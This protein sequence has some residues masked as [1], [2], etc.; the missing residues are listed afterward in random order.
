M[1]QIR[2]GAGVRCNSCGGMTVEWEMYGATFLSWLCTCCRARGGMGGGSA[3]ID[4]PAALV[5]RSAG[6]LKTEKLPGGMF[7]VGGFAAV[8]CDACTDAS[9]YKNINQCLRYKC[10]FGKVDKP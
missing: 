3:P 8:G 5:A 2:S 9:S 1:E 7:L 10:E 4:D 6:Y